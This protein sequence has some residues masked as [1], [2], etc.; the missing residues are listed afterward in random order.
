MIS[1]SVNSA[2]GVSLNAP[3]FP[4]PPGRCRSAFFSVVD[5]LLTW[6]PD[7]S[8][9]WLMVSGRAVSIETQQGNI[10][11]AEHLGQRNH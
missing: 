11:V 5:R 9:N 10:L 4:V 6:R 3:V 2:P 7:S 8:A 1:K